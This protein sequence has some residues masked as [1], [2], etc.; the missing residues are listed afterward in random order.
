MSESVEQEAGLACLDPLGRDEDP[1][2]VTHR[3]RKQGR[4]PCALTIDQ[5]TGQ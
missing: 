2:V 4:S 3:S 5:E 1:Y